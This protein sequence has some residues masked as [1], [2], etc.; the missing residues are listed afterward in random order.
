MFLDCTNKFDRLY[1]QF[2]RS[3]CGADAASNTP[4]I[5]STLT[6]AIDNF[7]VFCYMVSS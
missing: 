4:N 6:R 2:F 7:S 5:R 1:Q 3:E